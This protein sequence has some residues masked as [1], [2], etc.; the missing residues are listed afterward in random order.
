ME[1]IRTVVATEFAWVQ[2]LIEDLQTGRITWNEAW[3]AEISAQ[4]TAEA[5]E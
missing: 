5:K 2:A 1:Y 4:L 3:K